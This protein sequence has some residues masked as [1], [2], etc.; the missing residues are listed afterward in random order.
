MQYFLMCFYVYLGLA[1]VQL[2]YGLIKSI[3]EHR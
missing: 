2:I 3:I 1:F